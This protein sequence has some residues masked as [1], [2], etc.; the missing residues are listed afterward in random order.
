VIM[1]SSQRIFVSH[2]HHDN[3]FT[4]RLVEDLRRVLGD[5]IAVWYDAKGGLHGGDA[6]WKKIMQEIRSRPVFIIILSPK[7]ADSSWVNSEIDLAWKQMHSPI[8]KHI[9][10]LLYQECDIRDDLDTL[11]IIRFMTP[12]SYEEAFNELLLA[13]GLPPEV[14]YP[15][16]PIDA[17]GWGTSPSI[18]FAG[19]YGALEEQPADALYQRP[20]SWE[21]SSP[22]PYTGSWGAQTASTPYAPSW[23]ASPQYSYPESSENISEH[24]TV[25]LNQSQTPWGAQ[26]GKEQWHEKGINHF[27]LKQYQQAIAD[28]T[29]AIT[30]DPNYFPAYS[31]RGLSYLVLGQYD[32]A[33]ADFDQVIALNPNN[34]WAYYGRALINEQLKQYDRALADFDQAIALNPNFAEAKQSRTQLRIRRWFP[35]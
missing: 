17:P 21:T 22:D 4:L 19:G 3:V 33:L 7:A 9:I 10:P 32:L 15:T 13:L 28:E 26:E 35:W 31:N 16:S 20:A 29:Q 8:G 14:N 18:P 12:N 23:Q 2:S 1:M 27:N 11:H 24:P 5:E 34:A 6:W 30:L 25:P